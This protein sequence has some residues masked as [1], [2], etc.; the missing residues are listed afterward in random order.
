MFQNILT[1][2]SVLLIGYIVYRI[3]FLVWNKYYKTSNLFD[4]FKS[5][6]SV[7]MPSLLS[8]QEV[9][10]QPPEPPKV[11]SPSGPNPP[12]TEATSNEPVRIPEERPMDPYDKA[13]SEVPI[14]NNMRNPERSFGPNVDNSGTGRSVV[15][16]TASNAVSSSLSSFSPEFAQNGG[17]FMDGIKAN[18]FSVGDEYATI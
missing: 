5:S 3:G 18:D 2:V 10:Q 4:S 12:N 7:P 14:K 1:V 13:E 9:T 16:G 8:P 11:V 15:A 6:Q 17:D